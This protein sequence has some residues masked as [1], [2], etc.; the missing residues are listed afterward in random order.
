M[1]K[2]I[3]YGALFGILLVLTIPGV[4]FAGGG[5][6]GCS[7]IGTW[8]GVSPIPPDQVPPPMIQPP[9]WDPTYLSGWSVTVTG[10]SNNEGTNHFEYR[11]LT[12]RL[13][14]WATT[15]LSHSVMRSVLATVQLR[16]PIRFT[17]RALPR[18]SFS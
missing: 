2:N 5:G 4:A 7:N 16:C 14:Y 13:R 3:I 9:P 18:S 10:K 1:R 8:F 15:I 11:F 17:P 12:Q 6:K